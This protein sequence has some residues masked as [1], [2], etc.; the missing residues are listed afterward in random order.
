MLDTPNLSLKG[1]KKLKAHFVGQFKIVKVVG[2]IACKLDLGHRLY[3]VHDVFHVSLLQPHL[4]GGDG[5]SPLEP[6]VV[7]GED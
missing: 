4:V 5:T 2:P 3:G 7:D 6:I 1:N